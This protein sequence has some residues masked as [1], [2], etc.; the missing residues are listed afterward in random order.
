MQVRC[1]GDWKVGLTRTERNPPGEMTR[2]KMQTEWKLLVARMQSRTVAHRCDN[3]VEVAL[4]VCPASLPIGQLTKLIT[5]RRCA[6][7]DLMLLGQRGS[8]MER[9]ESGWGEDCPTD[10]GEHGW[11]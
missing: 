6:G 7:P 4:G 2:S 8:R 10:G 9:T 5:E 11:A 1:V 3:R